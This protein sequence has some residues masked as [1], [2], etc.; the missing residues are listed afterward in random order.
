MVDIVNN[1]IC[2]KQFTFGT[3][4]STLSKLKKVYFFIFIENL[5]DNFEWDFSFIILE[6][7]VFSLLLGLYVDCLTDISSICAKDPLDS[8]SS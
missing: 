6:I 4:K 7:E 3:S 5:V 8:F 1:L 2:N